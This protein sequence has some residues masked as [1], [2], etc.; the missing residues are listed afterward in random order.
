MYYKRYIEGGSAYV[1]YRNFCVDCAVKE[2]KN[3]MVQA[4]KTLKPASKL[5]KQYV[6]D[7]KQFCLSCQNKYKHVVGDCS[8]TE[9]TCKYVIKGKR[10]C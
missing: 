5:A 3:L 8:P 6:E 4:L 2:A 9:R 1:Q 10:K 7:D